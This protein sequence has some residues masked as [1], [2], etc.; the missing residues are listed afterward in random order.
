MKS[1]R[2]ILEMIHLLGKSPTHSEVMEEIEG[3]IYR[4]Y[5]LD[6]SLKLA[7]SSKYH[8]FDGL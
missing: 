1:Y 7:V 2:K 5:I 8:L 4:E 6:D 3:Y